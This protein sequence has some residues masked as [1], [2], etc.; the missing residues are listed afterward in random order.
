MAHLLQLL[1]QWTKKDHHFSS[2]PLEVLPFL[3]MQKTLTW[4]LH[5][6]TRW[7]SEITFVVYVHI[8]QSYFYSQIFTNVF[9]GCI[10]FSFM[11]L[12]YWALIFFS[13]S[14]RMCW[15]CYFQNFHKFVWTHFSLME[16]LDLE[17]AT[18]Y[19]IVSFY[20]F[21]FLHQK[22]LMWFTEAVW[23]RSNRKSSYFKNLTSKKSMILLNNF[24]SS[25]KY[26]FY[27]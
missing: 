20:Y 12:K 17:F 13:E 2:I 18:K 8:C 27:I 16:H 15:E 21:Q 19:L 23:R 22:L 25:T 26:I 4:I 10:L 24:N 14:T 9:N 1:S 11:N 5:R 6:C 3:S 7:E